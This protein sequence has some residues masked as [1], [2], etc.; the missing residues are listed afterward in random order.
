MKT[1]AMIGLALIMMSAG[2]RTDFDKALAD[3]RREHKLVMLKFSGSDWC[4]PCIRMEKDVFTNDSFSHFAADNLVMVNADF[5]RLSKNKLEKAVL[6]QN[7]SLAE[8]YNK[9]GHFPLTL[10][11]DGNGKVI[12][13]WEGYTG[14]RP[15]EF[16]KQIKLIEDAI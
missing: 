5:P 2:W 12:K 6:K 15:Q 10:L 16:I 7:E 11:I 1:I 14:T 9:A 4:L 8:R 13:V 3:A